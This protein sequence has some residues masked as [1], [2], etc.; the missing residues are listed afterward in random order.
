MANS[1]TKLAKDLL[2]DLLKGNEILSLEAAYSQCNCDIDALA[3]ALCSLIEKEEISI[4]RHKTRAGWLIGN[5]EINTPAGGA[6]WHSGRGQMRNSLP[7]ILKE[8]KKYSPCPDFP[9]QN[10]LDDV[11]VK[12][13]I[14]LL[15]DGQPRS[16][17][18]I[19]AATGIE[20]ITAHIC[21]QF[22]RLPDGRYTLPD[23]SGAREYFFEYIKEKPRRLA[24]LLRLFRKHKNIRSLLATGESQGHLIRLPHALITTSDSPEG[25][26]EL[27]RRRQLKLCHETLNCL[28]SPFFTLKELGINQGVFH[29]I[30]D[31]YTV[32]VIFD[33]KEYLCLR[34]EFPGDIIAE[35]LVDITGRYFVPPDKISAPAFLKTLSMGEKEA[36]NFLDISED[37][38]NHLIQTNS[39]EVFFLDGKRRMWR[40]D[41]EQLRM[42]NTLLRNLTKEHE[43]LKIP[44]AAVLLGVTT[45]QLK[46]LVNEGKLDPAG[47]YDKDLKS[48]HFF[49]RRDI[50]ELQ[51]S[52]PEI[53][54]SWNSIE[55]NSADNSGHHG[56]K[57]YPAKKRPLRREKP[58]PDNERQLHLDRFQIEAV[59]ALRAGHSVLLSAPTGN[60]KTLVAEILAR[61]LMAAGSGMVYTSPLKA[62]SNQKYRDFKET[63]G[64]DY[65]GLVTG[66]ISVNP[67]APLLIM[68]TEIFRNWCLGEPE[69]LK[70]TTYV[71]FDEIHYLDDSERGTTW[72]ESILFAPQHIKLLGLSATVPNIEEIAEWI[73]SVRREKVTI[74][75]EKKRQ[76]P[77]KINWVTPNG[78]IVEEN[79]AKQEVD[80]LAEYLKAFHNRRHWAEE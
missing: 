60:G 69:Q 21:Q 54:S 32:T 55:K 40:K 22:A 58:T 56:I 63:F 49:K 77:L 41:I 51:K 8:L 16:R 10:R 11:Q 12:S 42:N 1:K 15:S 33:G 31:K 7:K 45:G 46:R 27:E 52:L 19:I 44:R 4:G 47:Y 36:L 39:I 65:V 66:D 38:L 9:S 37:I 43:K 61:D 73:S 6:T 20:N 13:I 14:E 71:V 75:E 72:E 48:G 30:A 70:K 5:K 53:L 28:A 34:R 2:L 62:L 57:K 17:Q 64:L 24:D 80:E 26:T 74:I 23:S 50:E 3:G 18:Q 59:E 35:Q 76:V 79:E 78:Q 29:N 25:R 68:T 67:G